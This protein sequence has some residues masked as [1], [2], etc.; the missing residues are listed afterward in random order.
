MKNEMR[1]HHHRT[2]ADLIEHAALG[3]VPA[4]AADARGQ[5][6]RVLRVGDIPDVLGHVLA[7]SEDDEHCEM[8][9][10][11]PALERGTVEVGDVVLV[12]RGARPKVGLVGSGS[13]GAVASANLMVL[14]PKEGVLLGAVLAWWLDSPQGAD[15]LG[16][17]NRSST[18]GIPSLSVKDVLKLAVPVPPRDVQDA[19]AALL[20]AASE[21][22]SAERL[23]ATR[24]QDLARALA[25]RAL[26]AVDAA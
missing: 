10:D 7:I 5:V 12:A 24:R 14:R 8:F 23:A 9:P 3:P 2:L 17:A 16:R 25:H 26:F 13:E 21:A 1:Q 20:T 6:R 18:V 15:A 19:L 11:T 4:K 22:A